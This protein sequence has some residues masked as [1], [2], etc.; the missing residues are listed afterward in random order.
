LLFNGFKNLGEN[1]L[2]AAV[3]CKAAD[4]QRTFS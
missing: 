2:Q 1:D 3:R 4:L